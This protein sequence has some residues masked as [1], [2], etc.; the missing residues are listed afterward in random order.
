MPEMTIKEWAA[1]YRADNEA[2]REEKKLRL[3][4][5]T[6]EESVRS[7]FALCELALAFSGS[8]DVP[9]ELQ[10]RRENYFTDLARKWDLLA[11]RL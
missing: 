1:A 11:Q 8:F 10:E 4:Q 3:P 7:Y 9:V 6:V 5:E 2:E